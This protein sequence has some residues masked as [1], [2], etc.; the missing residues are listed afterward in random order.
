MPVQ[1]LRRGIPSVP[2]GTGRYA[3]ALNNPVKYSDPNG[4]WPDPPEWLSPFSHSIW[5]IGVVLDLKD[6]VGAEVSIAGYANAEAFQDAVS[7]LDPRYIKEFDL[8]LNVE[9]TLSAGISAE[10]NGEAFVRGTEGSVKD[11]AGVSLPF[12]N[13]YPVNLGGCVPIYSVCGKAQYEFEPTDE[14]INTTAYQVGVGEGVDA[15]V[16]VV[17]VSAP[18]V[19]VKPF[20]NK[21]EWF[22]W[23]KFKEEIFKDI[24]RYLYE[25]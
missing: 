11:Q 14:E 12:E 7:E 23:S 2:D 20:E 25:E 17:T 24:K 13:G 16:D 3:Y 1:V 19:Y 6:V 10:V 21:V 9:L 5:S 15:S 8:S 4:H 18:I 22:S